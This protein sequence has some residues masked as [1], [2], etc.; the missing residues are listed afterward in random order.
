MQRAERELSYSRPRYIAKVPGIAL[1]FDHS[2][3]YFDELIT[4]ALAFSGAAARC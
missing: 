1:P 2:K 3:S 4:Y